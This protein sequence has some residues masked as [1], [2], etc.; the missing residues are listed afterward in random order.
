MYTFFEFL[1]SKLPR[2]E[3][4]DTLIWQLTQTSVFEV[5]YYYIFLLEPPIVS[6]PWKSIWCIKVPKIVPFFLWTMAWGSILTIDN[7]IKR[8][9]PLVNWCRYDEETV[10]HILLQCKFSHALWSKILLLLGFSG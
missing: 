10:N 1:Y 4:D 2:G 7:L 6:F 5:S 9:L 8:G 3:G